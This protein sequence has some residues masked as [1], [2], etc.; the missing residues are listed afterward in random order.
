MDR[1]QSGRGSLT[2][3]L[4]RTARIWDAKTG[5]SLA[6]LKG[7]TDLIYFASFSPDGECVL[8]TSRDGTARIW[9]SVRCR[10]RYPKVAA[11]RTARMKYEA[12]IASEL[13]AGKSIDVITASILADESL[14]HEQRTGAQ[15]ALF[16]ARQAAEQE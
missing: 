6:E 9:D 15:A 14:T 3:S 5:L 10:V 11:I 12:R 16:A 1:L 2:A 8:T 7:H 4:D 13:G